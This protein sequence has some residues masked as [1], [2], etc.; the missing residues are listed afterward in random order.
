MGVGGICPCIPCYKKCYDV[1]EIILETSQITKDENPGSLEG[2]PL[3]GNV[4][5]PDCYDDNQ[6]D[7]DN[8]FEKEYMKIINT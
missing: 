4:F 1:H 3:K 6:D 7:G 8:A 5:E 2:T